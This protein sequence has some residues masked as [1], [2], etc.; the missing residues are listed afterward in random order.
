M[1]ASFCRPN[2]KQRRKKKE[3]KK[4]RG[5][6]CSAG[7]FMKMPRSGFGRFGL[8]HLAPTVKTVGADVVTQMHF[9]SCRLYS[10]IRCSQ[11]I[12]R[13]VHAAFGRRFFVLLNGHGP[14]L[15]TNPL[16]KEGLHVHSHFDNPRNYSRC[17]STCDAPRVVPHSFFA[18]FVADWVLPPHFPAPHSADHNWPHQARRAA[19]QPRLLNCRYIWLQPLQI[20]R[21]LIRNGA[22]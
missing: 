17:P 2:R 3:T 21:Y 7:L 22:I 15:Y 19:V 14:L 4:A 6:T 1:F 5:Y 10:H 16:K 11:R 9:A 8:D 18:R 13:A 12:M 20:W